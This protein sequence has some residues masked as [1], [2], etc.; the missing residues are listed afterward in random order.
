MLMRTTFRAARRRP[1]PGARRRDRTMH[2]DRTPARKL[3]WRAA[4][5]AVCALG[6]LLAC[7]GVRPARAQQWAYGSNVTGLYRINTATG[8][9]T[10][11]YSG[12]P[13][14]SGPAGVAAIAERPSDGM[15]FFIVGNA[16]NDTTYRWDPATPATAPVRLGNTGAGVG[17]MPRMGFD[18]SGN[19]YGINVTTTQIYSISQ[20]TGAATA[21]GSAL[22]GGPA[23]QTGGDLAFHPSSGLIYILTGTASP[24]TIYTVPVTGGALT[25]RGTVSGLPGAPSGGAFNA[26]GTYYVQSSTSNNLYTAPIAGGAATLVGSSG[27]ALQDIAAVP[28]A[29]PTVTLGFAP[30][31]V[32]QTGV[33]IL[34]IT[35]TNS[36]AVAQRGAAFTD[37]YPANLLNGTTPA[38]ATTCAGGTV[39]A[40]A[41]GGSVALAGGTIPAGGSCTVTVNVTSATAGSRVNTLAA[42]A[43]TTVIGGTTAA[44]SATLTVL[45]RADLQVTKT[46]SVASVIK[47]S[48]LT[49]IIIARNLGP[50]A[51]VGATLTDVFPAAVSAVA[52]TCTATAG[53]ACPASGAG[54]ISTS[55]VNLLV[56][57]AATFRATATASGAAGWIVN[58]ATGS[59]PA[60]TDDP[61]AN[62][63]ATDSTLLVVYGVTVT[64]DGLDTVPR[65]PSTASTGKYSYTFTLT[66]TTNAAESFDLLATA[67]TAGT[68]VTIDSITGAG[69]TRG[70]PPDSARLASIGAGAN[71]TIAV[72]YRAAGAATGSLDTIRLRGR[73]LVRPATALDSG[74]SY[75]RIV[76]PSLVLQ[77]TVNPPGAAPPGTDLTYTITA[78][79][80]GSD[81]AVSVVAVDSVAAQVRFQVGSAASTLPAGVTATVAYSNDAG[82]TWTYTPVS[83]GC[84]APAGFDGCV[85]RVRWSLQN[86]LSSVAPNNVASF[87]FVARIK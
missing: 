18:L 58:T 71:A 38:G 34:T 44:S 57:G 29:L 49:Y 1:G 31:T 64:T 75:V 69:V 68:F 51:V 9:G 81:P 60:G 21:T 26:A 45:P 28:V 70:A 72:W 35:L 50:S 37:T 47:G 86:P 24:Y 40:A 53:S 87:S 2:R 79:N 65:L 62:S 39:T 80:A 17:Y 55:A 22:T 14:T 10:L 7:A 8:A 20:T 67:G 76:R 5:Q 32:G 84:A 73:S 4:A 52:W 46:D 66:N 33:S 25:N 61:A 56:N 15:L 48:T 82:A 78:T 63:A 11:L 30:A 77:K 13:F 42:G 85:N 6:A 16:G 54:N 12:A 23:G 3:P 36:S 41:G 43:V 83:L 59:P 19:L 74:W 27:A